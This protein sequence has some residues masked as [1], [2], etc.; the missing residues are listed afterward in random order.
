MGN[1]SPALVENVVFGICPKGLLHSPAARIVHVIGRGCT[2]YCQEAV[3]GIVCVGMSQTIIGDVSGGIID[4]A[5]AGNVVVGVKRIGGVRTAACG[6]VL[7]PAVAETVVFVV[8]GLPGL[9]GL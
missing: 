3:L 7:L 1:H 5:T 8:K 2:C 6:H 4:D 9:A